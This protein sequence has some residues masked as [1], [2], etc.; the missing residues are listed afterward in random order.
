LSEY[1]KIVRTVFKDVF[2]LRIGFLLFRLF[3]IGIMLDFFAFFLNSYINFNL[4]HNKD[5]TSPFMAALSNVFDK[6]ARK[7]K[8]TESVIKLQIRT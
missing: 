2:D 3:I 6:F 5:L 4:A 7:F 8:N 1:D